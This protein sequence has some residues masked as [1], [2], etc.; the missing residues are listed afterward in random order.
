MTGF[1]FAKAFDDTEHKVC[2]LL[3][4]A[5]KAACNMAGIDFDSMNDKEKMNMARNLLK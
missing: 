2:V 5:L 3:L 4:D 1:E